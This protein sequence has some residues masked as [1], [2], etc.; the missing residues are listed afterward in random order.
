VPLPPAP[1]TKFIADERPRFA[2]LSAQHP[3]LLLPIRIE[4]RFDVPGKQLKIRIY[5]DAIHQDGHLAKPSAEE[6]ELAKQYWTLRLAA[7][8]ATAKLEVDRWLCEQVP[9]R[10][11]AYL[12][13]ISKPT[14]DAQGKPTWP[15]PT[16]RVETPPPVAAALPDHF[17]AVGWLDGNRRF[18]AFGKPVR[19]KPALAPTLGKPAWSNAPGVLPVDADSA[20]LIDYGEA[21][22]A[23]MAITVDLGQEGLT[24]LLTRGLDTLLIVGARYETAAVGATTLG[25]LLEGHLYD[26][27]LEFVAQ[28]TPT[29]NTETRRAGWT[30][31]IDDLGDHF[32]RE[33]GEK[34]ATKLADSEALRLAAALGVPSD[35]LAR[36]IGGER[37]E[38]R[39][40]AAMHEVLWEVTWGAYLDDLLAIE[41]QSSVVDS[42]V[43]TRARQW[44]VQHVRGGASLPTLAVGSQPYGV[45][46]MRRRTGVLP[47]AADASTEAG[48]ARGLELL[49]ERLVGRWRTSLAQVPRIDGVDSSDFD[50]HLATLLGSLPHPDRFVLRRLTV[51]RTLLMLFWGFV[52]ESMKFNFPEVGKRYTVELAKLKDI[53]GQIDLLKSLRSRT[54]KPTT[55]GLT[56]PPMIDALVGML[57]VHRRRL[58]PLV[59]I[60]PGLLREVFDVGVEDAR[61]ATSGYGNATADRLFTRPLVEKRNADTGAR[62]TDYLKWL[63]AKVPVEGLLPMGGRPAVPPKPEPVPPEPTAELTN[64]PPLLYQLVNKAITNLPNLRR[65]EVRSALASLAACEV[66]ELELRLRETLGLAAHRIDAWFTSLARRDLAV[67]RSKQ[68]AGVQIGAWGFVESLRPDGEGKRESEGFIHAP[69]LAHA[70]TSAV[71]RAGWRAHGGDGANELA[72]DLRSHRVRLALDLLDGLR[73]GQQLGDMLGCRFERILHDEKL[74]TWIDPCRRAV[75]ANGAAPSGPVDGLALLELYQAG[76]LKLGAD[77][78]RDG[79]IAPASLGGVQA[80]LEQLQAGFDAIGDASIAD[81]VHLLLQGNDSRAAATLDAIATGD[82]MP[83]ELRSLESPRAAITIT[84]R[85]AIAFGPAAPAVATKPWCAGPLA[86]LEL[87]LEN[88]LAG[89]LPAPSAIKVRVVHRDGRQAAVIGLDAIAE[90]SGLSLLTWLNLAPRGPLDAHSPWTRLAVAHVRTQDAKLADERELSVDADY[91]ADANAITLADFGLLARALHALLTRA[92]PLDARDL[93]PPGTVTATGWN[94]AEATARFTAFRTALDTASKLEPANTVAG[95]RTALL[96]LADF[97]LPDAIPRSGSSPDERVDLRAQWQAVLAKLAT[98]LEADEALANQPAPSDHEGKIDRL[99]QRLAV[100]T[101]QPVVFLPKLS[102]PNPAIA[103]ALARSNQLLGNDPTRATTWLHDAAKVR[104]ELDRL[105]EVL[106][107]TDLGRDTGVLTPTVGQIPDAANEPWAAVAAPLERDRDRLCLWLIGADLAGKAPVAGLLIDEFAEALPSG[108]QTTGIALHFD[109]PS[110]RPP[111]SLL[112]AVPRLEGDVPEPWTFEILCEAVLDTIELAKLRAVDPD[113]LQGYGHHAPA[114]FPGL[115]DAGAQP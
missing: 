39:N 2:K 38:E 114:I 43:R 20:W 13:R 48:F 64:N 42:T 70:A 32:A 45:L 109:A 80:A 69:S 66:D 108:D 18:V 73:A 28:G 105:A 49:L 57:E 115:L 6:F 31:T 4:T 91:A 15:N 92:R 36:V 10:R 99:R 101:D 26:Q 34:P 111:Q 17:A 110:S 19:A 65:D 79:T 8:D 44:F 1:P 22:A 76:T 9:E 63:R 59:D 25:S 103:T 84:H 3:L 81:A 27:G 53:D 93:A 102:T 50:E 62:A 106:A 90:K 60:Y 14:L 23:G 107:L 83:P 75:L 12:A 71:L 88:W 61:I 47:A 58:A 96:E 87:G 37:T 30:P 100:L 11:A 67:L 77:T 21:L 104:P 113:L 40:A 5:P 98:R 68:S 78:L 72:V 16:Q 35:L 74:D 94:V 52:L 85:V 56:L 112:L 95:L 97:G 46:P 24:D 7:A 51:Q 29:N 41:G 82:A 86:T 33:L 89:L 55:E 54:D